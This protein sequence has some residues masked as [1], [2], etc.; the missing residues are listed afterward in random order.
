MRGRFARP[1]DPLVV[2]VVKSSGLVSSSEG[3]RWG[4]ESQRRASAAWRG[5]EI[6]V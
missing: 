6:E 4:A 2:V 1:E 3:K 5:C